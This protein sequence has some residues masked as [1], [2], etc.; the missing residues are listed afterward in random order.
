MQACRIRIWLEMEIAQGALPRGGVFIVKLVSVIS[1]KTTKS[2][3]QAAAWVANTAQ[4]SMLKALSSNF[5]FKEINATFNLHL[6]YG[7][8][9]SCERLL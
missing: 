1:G 6:S 8:K 7:T 3:L 9:L 4:R 2:A 5:W